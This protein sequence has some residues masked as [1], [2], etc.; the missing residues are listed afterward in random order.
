[1][2]ARWDEDAGRALRG[3]EIA[4][5]ARRLVTCADAVTNQLG[6]VKPRW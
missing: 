4:R 3:A 1:M 6:G 2:F 5:Q